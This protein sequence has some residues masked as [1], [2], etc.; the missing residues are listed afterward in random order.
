[1]RAEDEKMDSRLRGNDRR[2]RGNGLNGRDG[3]KR[4]LDSCFRRNDQ[5]TVGRYVERGRSTKDKKM[6]SRLRGNDKRP[7]RG[8]RYMAA[9]SGVQNIVEGS[10]A[11]GTSRKTEMKLTNV[12]RASLEELRKDYEDFL[13][14]KGIRLC[15]KS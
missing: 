2:G 1:M 14:Q 9:R 5:R 10:Q 3:R 15:E 13:R 11:S 12:A 4:N 8:R 6:D 7:S